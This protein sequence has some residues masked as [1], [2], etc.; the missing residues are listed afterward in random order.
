[1]TEE[2]TEQ[3]TG[4]NVEAAAPQQQQQDQNMVP[5]D[6]LQAERR[7]RQRMQEELEAIRNHVSMMASQN[8]PKEKDPMD[9]ANDDD[10]LTVGEAKKYIK[11]L[12]SNYR[13]SIEEMKFAQEHKDYQEV[14]QKYL[15]EVIK[16]NPRIKKSL[17]E[18]Q[19]FALAYELAKNSEAYRRDHFEK[20]PHQDAQRIVENSQ[21]AG[22]LSQVGSTAPANQARSY[23]TMSDQEFM[24]EVQKNLGYV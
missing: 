6:A 17:S 9:E 13:T 4:E 24:R 19:D 20:K 18:T 22:N 11:S 16:K 2:Y 5:V 1:M 23:K 3:P 7:E 8:Q 14:I 21:K 12:D 15:P 10:I